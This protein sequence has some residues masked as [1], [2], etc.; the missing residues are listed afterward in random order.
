MTEYL[1]GIHPVLETVKAGR[2]S[3]QRAWLADR[4]AGGRLRAVRAALVQGGVA[5]TTA[6][7]ETLRRLCG[8]TEH[9]GTVVETTEYPYAGIDSLAALNRVVLLDNVEDPQNVGAVL[10]SALFFGW[11]GVLLSQR[12]VPGVYPSVV[13]ASAGAAD[14]LMIVR[15]RSANRYLRWLLEHDFTVAV[16][17]AAGTTTP[18][19]LAA[20]PPAR[21][22]LVLGGE[23]RG[24]G[25]YIRMNADYIVGMP[26]QGPVT[27]LNASVAAGIVLHRL[28]EE[29]EEKT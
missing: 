5:T 6:G 14:H 4:D 25:Q 20:A 19:T 28:A 18:E 16:L 13:K 12:G 9:Q 7:R 24:V 23:H 8:S 26:G 3:V 21:L 27:S 11:R 10:R 15:D 2:R 1:Y 29:A 22:A 17:D